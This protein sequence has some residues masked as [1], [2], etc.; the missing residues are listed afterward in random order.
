MNL[1]AQ[2]IK[3][4]VI[5]SLED[6]K[7]KDIVCIDVKKLTSVADYMVICT[8]TSTRHV[9]SLADNVYVDL[10]KLGEQARSVEGDAG[11]EWVLVD[12]GDVLVHV[13]LEQARDFY[14]LEK[15]WSV[16]AE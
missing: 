14:E 5:S 2:T 7:A 1:S 6:L 16:P 10:K 12:F 11:A 4:A 13:M 15:L 8:G 9:K 3:D